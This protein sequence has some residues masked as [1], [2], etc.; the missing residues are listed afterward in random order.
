MTTA[1][2]GGE[3]SAARTRAHFTP[4][5]DPVPILQEA[6][7]GPGP[8]WTGEKSHPHQDSIPDCPACS[9]SLYRLSYLAHI[10]IYIYAHMWHS[11]TVI[12]NS[13]KLESQ[14]ITHFEINTAA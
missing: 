7:W 9:Q 8:V 6:E 10:Y 3:W 5:K 4:R 11:H 2:E 13:A 1:L 12:S 14:L